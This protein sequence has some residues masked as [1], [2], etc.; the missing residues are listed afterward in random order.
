[1]F[2]CNTIGVLLLA[3]IAMFHLI[4]V[5]NDNHGEYIDTKQNWIQTRLTDCKS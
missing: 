4:G 2:L 3:M 5:E 1:M